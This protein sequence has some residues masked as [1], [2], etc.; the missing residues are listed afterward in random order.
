MSRVKLE[1]LPNPGKEDEGLGH[2]GIE[3]YRHAP[4]AGVVRETG[5]NSRDAAA[6]LPVR[7]QY[8]VIEIDTS[9]VPDIDE[10]RHVIA[11]CARQVRNA[12]KDKEVAFFDQ[13]AK[14]VSHNKMTVLRISDFNTVGARGPSVSG[15]P[16]HSLVK[17]SGV[18]VKEQAHSGGSFGIGKNA[19]FAVSDVQAVFYSTLY[20]DA[21]VE[22][23][24]AQG[25]VVLISHEDLSG[26]PRR[27][28]G[29]WGFLGFE[30]I[31]AVSDAPVWARRTAVGTTVCV[32]GF[33]ET[34]EWQRRFA[35]TLV[36][37]FYPAIH[38]NEMEFLLDGGKFTV[39]RA[40]LPALLED[41]DLRR[42]AL[43]DN[44]EHEFQVAAGAYRCLTSTDST[45]KVVALPDIGEVEIRVLVAEGL[46]KKVFL[47][48]NGMVIADSLEHFGEKFARFPL[49]RDF[50][51]LVTPVRPEGSAYIKRLEDPK[52]S[53]LS[54]EGLPDPKQ[55]DR[56]K[57][58]MKRLGQHIR[59][60]VKAEA[61][62][63]FE[64]EVPLDEL[65]QYFASDE[66]ALDARAGKNDDPERLRYKI[67]ERKPPKRGQGYSR[68]DDDAGGGWTADGVG[69]GPS[70]PLHPGTSED[71][72][73]YGAQSSSGEKPLKQIQLG[74]VRNVAL[75]TAKTRSLYFTAPES[76]ECE[77]AIFA[78]GLNSSESLQVVSAS[79]GALKDGRV[80][81]QVSANERMRLDMEFSESYAGPI[82]LVARMAAQSQAA[83]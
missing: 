26:M 70:G 28:T 37:N 48:R 25:K 17:S 78:T 75:A 60:T 81:C 54:A 51:A 50:V 43:E 7:I 3:T 68:G 1:F 30:P 82:E 13:A 62:A 65:R 47:T 71:L 80:V 9:S 21:G 33:R 44:R 24:L 12:G 4:Y 67:Q 53:S 29:Y 83:K 5:Q 52:H 34:R 42:V 38:R 22:R 64:G 41:A 72:P 40:T 58:V 57:A 11:R 76:G 19:S 10:F 63:T 69:P 23:F 20:D 31:T 55:R 6:R 8:D 77:I 66:S 32:L 14:T 27:Q 73:P 35:V 79:S 56:V 15:T 18:S 36:E 2:A 61:L 16:F 59:E 39:N 74:D 45:V 46:P 49:Y